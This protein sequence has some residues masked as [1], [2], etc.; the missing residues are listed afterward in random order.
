MGDTQNTTDAG[1]DVD[2]DVNAGGGEEDVEPDASNN[3]GTGEDAAGADDADAADDVDAGDEGDESD[4]GAGDD[5]ADDGAEPPTRGKTAAD[6]VAERRGKKIKKLQQKAQNQQGDDDAGDDVDDDT[7]PNDV[8]ALVQKEVEKLLSPVLESQEEQAIDAEIADFLADNPDFE[9]YK[10]KVKRFAKHPSR[11]QIPVKSLFYE[12]A[13]DKLL[14]IGADRRANA[15]KKARQMQSGGGR[16]DVDK[17]SKSYKD[18][19]FDDVEKEVLNVK[20]GN[21]S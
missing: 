5:D 8:S 18:M 11:R 9:P 17:G 12:V 16:A 13:G 19:P 6:Y 14:K 7:D 3:D 20:I 21:N 4:D 10:D 1:A 2:V 15:D